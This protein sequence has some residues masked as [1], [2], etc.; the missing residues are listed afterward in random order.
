M[1]AERR[2]WLLQS[3]PLRMAAFSRRDRSRR[4]GIPAA[5]GSREHGLPGVGSGPVAVMDEEGDMDRFPEGGVLV[6]LGR[7]R[8]S[9]AS[10]PRQRPS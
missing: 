6:A 9:F 2:L 8:G 5:S 7:H 4:S 10:W 3:R 1:D